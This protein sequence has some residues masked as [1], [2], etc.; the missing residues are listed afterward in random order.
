[1]SDINSSG[2]IFLKEL[3]NFKKKAKSIPYSF[4]SSNFFL[5][6]QILGGTSANVLVDIAKYSDA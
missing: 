1:M 2:V 3:L 5:Q 6:G 4:N